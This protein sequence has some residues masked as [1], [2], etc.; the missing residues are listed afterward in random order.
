MADAPAS[1]SLG[2]AIAGWLLF[3]AVETA[4][5]VTF[6]YAGGTLDDSGGLVQMAIRAAQTPLVL[7]GFVLYFAGFLIWLTILKD[8]DLGRAFPM[9]AV[10]YV[11]TLVAA[12]TLFH[13]HLN[14]MR[15]A[16]VLVIAVGV[17]LLASDTPEEAGKG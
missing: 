13:E 17:A 7:L 15:I 1:K 8:I 2:K 9:T 5:Q 10:I 16:G 11:S 14:L 4:T 6:K 3:I 12:V